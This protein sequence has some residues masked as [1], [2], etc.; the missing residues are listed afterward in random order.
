MPNPLTRAL[1]ALDMLALCVGMGYPEDIAHA[2]AVAER[3]LA[4]LRPDHGESC[5]TTPV[6]E[7]RS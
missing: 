1:D 2:L 6:D 5:Y 3:L 7:T 4:E